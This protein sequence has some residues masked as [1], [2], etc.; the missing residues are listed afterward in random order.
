MVLTFFRTSYLKGGKAGYLH[1]ASGDTPALEYR[2][3]CSPI[4]KLVTSRFFRKWCSSGVVSA[5]SL[6]E[7]L[8]FTGF[9]GI[10]KD[11][12]VAYKQNFFHPKPS[13]GLTGTLPPPGPSPWGR[14]PKKRRPFPKKAAAT[15]SRKRGLGCRLGC[16]SPAG[17][18]QHRPKR[19]VRPGRTPKPHFAQKN[20]ARYKA[21]PR[22]GKR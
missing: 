17:N 7:T 10:F 8:D 11:T 1:T 21:S 4:S 15:A 14:F 16:C 3:L 5:F 2:R 9:S 20:A 18:A 6:R 19:Q 22:R 12:A 13:P